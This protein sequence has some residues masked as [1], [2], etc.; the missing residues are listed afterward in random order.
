M[1]IVDRYACSTAATRY[2]AATPAADTT[3]DDAST[4]GLST[5][6]AATSALPIAG[7]NADG[8]QPGFG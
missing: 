3:N 5:I 7:S 2:D 8:Y 4:Y 1:A 6:D